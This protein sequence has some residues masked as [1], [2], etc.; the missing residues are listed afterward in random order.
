MNKTNICHMLLYLRKYFGKFILNIWEVSESNLQHIKF[1]SCPMFLLWVEKAGNN[2]LIK[3]LYGFW[4]FI[5]PRFSDYNP[6]SEVQKGAKDVTV[7]LKAW[8]ISVIVS[9]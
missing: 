6:P 5:Y 1:Q 3:D 8:S 9:N 2:K 4:Y 7:K